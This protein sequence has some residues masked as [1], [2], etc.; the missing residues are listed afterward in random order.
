MARYREA[1]THSAGR[2]HANNDDLYHFF[3]GFSVGFCINE[4][5]GYLLPTIAQ[6]ITDDDWSIQSK[7][8]QVIFRAIVGNITFFFICTIYMCK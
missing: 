1:K 3:I 7:R 8:R 5:E 2:V 4:E 6:K